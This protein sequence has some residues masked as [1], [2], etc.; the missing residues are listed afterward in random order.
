MENDKKIL[1]WLNGELSSQEIE[2]LKKSPDFKT[3][4]KIAHYSSHL[5]TPTVDAKEA[6]AAFQ[7]RDKNK[8]SKVIPLNLTRWFQVAA[9]LFIVL[10][11][12]YFLWNNS[13]TTF[14]TQIAQTQ[15][16]QLPD[17]SEVI[18]N[19]ASKIS[20]KKN[21]WDEKRDLELEGEAYF[22][23]QKGKTFSV[24]TVDGIVKVLGTH[25][26]VKQRDNY[27]EVRC[28]EGLVSVT[29]NNE[30]VKLPPRKT[31]RL[32]NNQIENVADFEANAPSWLQ[33]ESSFDRIP[34]IQVINELERQ[35]GLKINTKD[36]NT[37]SLFTG[38]FTHTN[39]K[40]ALDAITIPLQ[41]RYK[42]EG[43]TVIFYKNAN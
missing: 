21:D 8:K 40:T 11:S 34:L 37:D 5:Q 43:K 24:K 19:A 20:F 27:F 26:N 31:F 30:T 29:H 41:I 9:A 6:L 28:Y 3:F 16:F 42:I 10:T 18:L 17:D 33:K 4:E 39:E 23:V 25:F 38:T 2:E 14:E 22:L 12:A 1:K 36:I 13:P 7:A 35:Y 15:T 32:I